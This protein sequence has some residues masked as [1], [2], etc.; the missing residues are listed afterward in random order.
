MGVP[1]IGSHT[2]TV[3]SA[4]PEAAIS[5]PSGVVPN[6]TDNTHLVRN[7]GFQQAARH[8]GSV[9]ERPRGPVTDHDTHP[10]PPI[11]PHLP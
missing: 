5:R 2:R 11:A 6:A 10:S 9:L 8:Q 7:S 1:A 4:E 3:P